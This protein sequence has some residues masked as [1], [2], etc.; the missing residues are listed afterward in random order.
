MKRQRVVVYIGG[1]N[2]TVEVEWSPAWGHGSV[3]IDGLRVTKWGAP[4]MEFRRHDF[5]ALGFPMS[6]IRSDGQRAPHAVGDVRLE[7]NG[8]PAASLGRPQGLL[9][10]THVSA[11]DKPCPQCCGGALWLVASDGTVTIACPA[12]GR[13]AI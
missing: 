12:C 13:F 5:T 2:R 7:I 10:P 3:V 6:V 8:T 4:F 1:Q 11:T 9:A